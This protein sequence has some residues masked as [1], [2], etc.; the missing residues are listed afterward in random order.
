MSEKSDLTRTDPMQWTFF[1]AA[2]AIG[3]LLLF[4]NVLLAADFHA[5]EAA[6]T[7]HALF[8][9]EW[10][11]EM[12]QYPTWASSLGDRRWNDR[13]EDLSSDAILKR[14]NHHRQVLAQLNKIDRGALTAAEQLN[15]DLFKRNYER[16]V[17]GFQ[18]RGFLL[19]LNQ[20][21]GVHTVNR[22]AD[23]LRFE[24]LKD[25]ADWLERL[26]ALPLRIDQTIALMRLG[27]KER[28]IHPKIVL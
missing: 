17:E 5:N 10:D 14:H 6:K 23:A 12:E 4:C 3:L 8:A 9:A 2:R 20:L 25:Y 27:I 19:P 1:C 18:Y 13:W 26:K 7:L 28:I 16:R 21:D 24:T 11:Y 15:Y 22:L